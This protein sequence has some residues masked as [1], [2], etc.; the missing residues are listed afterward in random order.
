MVVRDENRIGF[1]QGRP[2][3][4]GWRITPDKTERSGKHG[5]DQQ[6]FP[7]Q[8][9]EKGCLSDPGQRIGRRAPESLPVIIH[10]RNHYPGSR[11]FRPFFI[12]PAQQPFQGL[13][14]CRFA[15][16]AFQIGKMHGSKLLEPVFY[17]VGGM[18]LRYSHAN[19]EELPADACVV[20]QLVFPKNGHLERPYFEIR[21]RPRLQSARSG[22][23]ASF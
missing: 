18:F 3:Q 23:S 14:P 17:R 16:V 6:V 15:E 7:A 13:A 4:S 9:D 8:L 1:R 10:V 11:R 20:F 12:M 22:A 2:V 19:S 5:I 21:Q